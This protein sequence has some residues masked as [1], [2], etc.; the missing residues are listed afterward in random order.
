VFDGLFK[1]HEDNDKSRINA[2]ES[3]GV[4]TGGTGILGQTY[5]YVSEHIVKDHIE[6]RQVE[7]SGECC[8]VHQNLYCRSICFKI[9][10]ELEQTY[11]V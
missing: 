6:K 5:R 7:G 10:A 11:P 3:A 1:E 4:T 2:L 8:Y 9:G